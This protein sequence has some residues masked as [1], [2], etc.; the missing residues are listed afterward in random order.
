MFEGKKVWKSHRWDLVLP[1]TMCSA[2]KNLDREPWS[3]SQMLWQHQSS[4]YRKVGDMT[5]VLAVAKWPAGGYFIVKAR[6]KE[7]KRETNF[8]KASAFFEELAMTSM[9]T[10]TSM[11]CAYVF[12]QDLSCVLTRSYTWPPRRNQFQRIIIFCSASSTLETLYICIC[13]LNPA[14]RTSNKSRKCSNLYGQPSFSHCWQT[15]SNRGHRT[16]VTGLQKSARWW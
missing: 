16:V 14:S 15:P 10:C 4:K 1:N 13:S 5:R 8:K 6:R 11:F 9:S 3:C 7:N 2:K 12:K